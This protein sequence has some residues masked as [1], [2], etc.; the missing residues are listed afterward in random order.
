[1]PAKNSS[2]TKKPAK[3]TRLQQTADTKG[4]VLTGPK[5]S[6]PQ[7]TTSNR[8]RTQGGTTMKAPGRSNLP[9]SRSTKPAAK[10]TPKPAAKPT[11]KPAA[12][13]ALP[14]GRQGGAIVRQETKPENPRRTSA[15][16]RQNTAS[17]GTT[18]PNRVGQPPGSA[19]RQFGASVVNQAVNRAV[20]NTR[21]AGVTRAAGRAAVPVAI[22]NQIADIK[23]GFE[24]LAQSPFIQK[25]TK[26]GKAPSAGSR[27][28]PKA[29][30]P[31]TAKPKI[32]KP[33]L[34]ENA[35]DTGASR[36][37]YG[38]TDKPKPQPAASQSSTTTRSST[39]TRSS[40]PARSTTPAS[41][42]AARPTATTAPKSPRATASP[43]PPGTRGI[44]PV[45]SGAEYVR[46]KGSMSET[47]RQLR[48]MRKRSEERQKKK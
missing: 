32:D 37:A 43:K 5:G 39:S 16:S 34:Y 19:N 18:G 10:P 8:V 23:A 40:A 15:R 31:A 11:P 47:A 24:K 29:A 42:P 4:K 9:G 44:G 38:L 6:K 1:M 12:K 26:G 22:A 21:L 46:A 28:T 13:P 27:T 41:R 33:N 14:P 3:P 20:R 36:S 45:K 25:M 2:K 30:K 17:R 35:Y 7:S 48:E